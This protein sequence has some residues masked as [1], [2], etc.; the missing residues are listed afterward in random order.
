[1][2]CVWFVVYGLLFVVYGLLFVVVHDLCVSLLAR[3]LVCLFVVHGLLFCAF[4]FLLLTC[5]CPSVLIIVVF[6]EHSVHRCCLSQKKEQ[7]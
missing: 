2:I 5:V 7:Q 6:V 3:S 1:M 4:C